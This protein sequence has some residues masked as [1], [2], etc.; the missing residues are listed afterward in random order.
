MQIS[1]WRAK[2]GPEQLEYILE[3]K[4]RQGEKRGVKS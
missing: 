1:E 2:P 3:D 4:E